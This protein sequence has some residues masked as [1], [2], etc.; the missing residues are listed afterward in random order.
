MRV[1]RYHEKKID[2]FGK[3][4]LN[5]DYKTNIGKKAEQRDKQE[6]IKKETVRKDVFNKKRNN[7][8]SQDK[9]IND[10]TIDD[11]KS[12]KIRFTKRRDS[13][14]KNKKN[15]KK[16]ETYDKQKRSKITH[17]SKSRNIPEIGKKVVNTPVKIV[18]DEVKLTEQILSK[19]KMDDIII[20]LEKEM[21]EKMVVSIDMIAKLT[22]GS[23]I[24]VLLALVP[25]TA[26][27]I[28]LVLFMIFIIFMMK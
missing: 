25:L 13:D 1:S 6:E 4:I 7:K 2:G 15:R 12:E 28:L 5:G 8:S 27:Y 3:S 11:I 10:A 18:K 22:F 26:V 23:I 24:K 9:E 16:E 21:M 14:K 19:K 20:F 17:N